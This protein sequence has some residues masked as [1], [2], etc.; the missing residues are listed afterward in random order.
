MHTVAVFAV[1]AARCRLAVALEAEPGKP[2]ALAVDTA[3]AERN[4]LAELVAPPEVVAAAVAVV[5]LLVAEPIA[6]V[7]IEVV[8][9][10]SSAGTELAMP[11]VALVVIATE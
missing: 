4:I 2:V 6:A 7:D 3:A 5:A 8:L 11:E 9:T 1:A 10:Y